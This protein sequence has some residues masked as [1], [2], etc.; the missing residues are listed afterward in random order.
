MKKY[1]LIIS[2]L[3]LFG[4][5]A[6]A[7]DQGID[8]SNVDPATLT[9]EQLAYLQEQAELQYLNSD[10]NGGDMETMDLRPGGPRH[11]PRP[12][13][14]PGG[15]RHG[16]PYPY[17]GPRPWP[18][19]YP[20]P[21]PYPQPYPYP[22]PGPAFGLVCRSGPYYCPLAYAAPIGVSCQCPAF[23]GFVTGY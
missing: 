1:I 11:G 6:N 21:Y 10:L 23:W 17:P 7:Q 5:G 4:L 13:P 12:G 15:P 3:M 20:H 9:D 18:A 8:L 2:T 14:F 22:G 16:G 19:P